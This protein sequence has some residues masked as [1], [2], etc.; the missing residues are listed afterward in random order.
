[1]NRGAEFRA[2][3]SRRAGR[4]RELLVAQST[5]ASWHYVEPAII[6]RAQRLGDRAARKLRTHPVPDQRRFDE[7][8]IQVQNATAYGLSPACSREL[9]HGELYLST[10]Q[11]L[12][13]C[14]S[15]I[16]TSGAES[17]CVRRRERHLRGREA[18]SDA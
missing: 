8:A 15:H 14:Q 2:P 12:W 18:G 16:G 9:Q 11:R 3:R 1:M 13:H 7:Q 4:G 17:A 10:V 6:G 5:E